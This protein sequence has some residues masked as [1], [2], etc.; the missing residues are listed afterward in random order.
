[1]GGTVPPITVTLTVLALPSTTTVTLNPTA[2]DY[3]AQAMDRTSA[4]KTVTVSNTGGAAAVFNLSLPSGSGG[5]SFERQGGTC[6][7]NGQQ[8]AAGTSCTVGVVFV[9]GCTAGS[10]AGDMTVQGANYPTV[11]TRLTGT[12]KAGKCT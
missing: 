3:G 1:M 8:L 7:A 10:G 4:V 9:T 5:W 6:P 12:I 11:T 2:M